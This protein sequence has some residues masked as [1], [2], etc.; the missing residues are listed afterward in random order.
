MLETGRGVPSAITP[1]TRVRATYEPSKR[2]VTTGQTRGHSDAIYVEIRFDSGEIDWED[3]RHLEPVPERETRLMAFQR[4]RFSGA[5]ALRDALLAEKVRG[6]LTDVHYAMGSGN[7]EFLPHQFKPVMRFVRSALGRM[8]IADEVGLGKTIEAIYIWRE[9]QAR[10]D[11]RRLLVVCPAGL[12]RKW[13]AELASRFSIQADIKNASELL[14]LVQRVE[15]D[16]ACSFAAIVGLEAIRAKLPEE[17]SQPIDVR[18]ELMEFLD[19]HK[20][21]V[22]SAIFDL[23]IIDEA[24]HM[25]NSATASHQAGQVV[26]EASSHAVLLSATPL[27]TSSDNLYRL[28]HLLDPDRFSTPDA[29]MALQEANAPLTQAVNALQANPPRAA[30]FRE[31]MNRLLQS[32]FFRNDPEIGGLARR[33]DVLVKPAARVD[34][35]R[36]LEAR[37]LYGDVMTRT[38]KRDVTINKVQRTSRV[39]RV[40]LSSEENRFY[41]G[42]TRQLRE[43][44]AVGDIGSVF[45]VIA[46]ERQLSSSIPA[47]L[48]RWGDTEALDD[49]LEEAVLQTIEAKAD[50]AK[51]GLGLD[52]HAQ[53]FERIDSKFAE[54]LTFLREVLAADATEKFIVFTFFRGTI[55]YLG[56]RLAEAGIEAAAIWG[57]MGDAKS[58]EIV[59]FRQG[60]VSVLLSTEVGSEGID[61]QFARF[62]INY[63]LPWN[64]MRVEQR[65]G[66]IDRIGQSAE[67][68]NIV[69]FV[70]QGTIDET[71]IDRLY[72]RIGIFTQS[73]GDLEEIIGDG[74]EKLTLDYFRNSLSEAELAARLDANAMATEQNRALIADIEEDIAELAGHA[75]FLHESIKLDRDAGR[76]VRPEDL[77]D[78]LTGFLHRHYPGSSLR[79]DLS[80][81]DR[82]FASFSA[83]ARGDLHRFI[84]DT[85]PAR[86]TRLHVPGAAAVPLI[87]DARQS[88]AGGVRPELVDLTHPVIH[89]ARAATASQDDR[90]ECVVA[91]TLSAAS[92]GV[93]PGFYV[94]AVD[95]WRMDGVRKDV[96]LVTAVWDVAADGWLDRETSDRLIDQAARDGVRADLGDDAEVYAELLEVFAKCEDELHGR[97]LSER[98]QF[99]EDNKRMG[100]RDARLIR[101]R[102]DRRMR[103]L[104]ARLEAQRRSHDLKRQRA[105]PMTEGL[106]RREE[107]ARDQRLH[108]V[109]QQST[110]QTTMRPVAGG[111]IVVE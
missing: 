91:L 33:E 11:A 86:T 59:R 61:L 73:V 69:S 79:R 14:E 84:Q 100:E 42:L 71:I 50:P 54:L 68:I 109:S 28:L 20:A 103:D 37:S 51:L 4:F 40:K 52:V 58:E 70:I 9:L 41:Q 31:A 94:F 46:R 53:D 19:R 66:R 5:K 60:G 12:R 67:K 106:M 1:N 76:W 102:A 45:A 43:A 81:N 96:R 99:R 2:G 26:I 39:I 110:P 49:V 47:T 65:I 92:V 29:F 77:S 30:A 75:S 7:A 111:V 72:A 95:F 13:Q 97:Y 63:D 36:L 74:I 101:E 108:V 8:L 34:A 25:R 90:S 32:P 35:L 56:R 27:Q 24:H 64:P 16:P 10:T 105:A 6:E 38:R 55:E 3:S 93:G 21:S 85:R 17:G 82:L 78:F 23:T 22:E 107:Q 89:W 48:A 15:R 98:T 80:D 18:E 83:E 57:G 62:V 88:R 104:R 44:A 87:F